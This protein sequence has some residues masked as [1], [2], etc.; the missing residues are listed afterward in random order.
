M[1]PLTIIALITLTALIFGF[2]A[3]DIRLDAMRGDID[4]M[5]SLLHAVADAVG[6]EDELEDDWPTLDAV[7]EQDSPEYIARVEGLL[8]KWQDADNR[9][10]EVEP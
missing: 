8:R 5:E 9:D 10:R 3:I 2:W 1:I 7:A 4:R 6:V